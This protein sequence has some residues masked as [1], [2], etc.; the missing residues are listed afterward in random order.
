MTLFVGIPACTITVRDTLQHATPARYGEALILAANAVPVLLPPVGVAMLDVLDRARTMAQ[1]HASETG[2]LGDG[3]RRVLEIL[4][5]LDEK[6]PVTDVDDEALR[7]NEL[8]LLLA[9]KVP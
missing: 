8:R 7:V 1:S 6:G 3:A 9:R 5:L 4:A 2:R